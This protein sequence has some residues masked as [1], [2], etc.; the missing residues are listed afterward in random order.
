MASDRI[1]QEFIIFR[2]NNTAGKLCPQRQRELLTSVYAS[3][4]NF[5]QINVRYSC[6]VLR[7]EASCI[8]ASMRIVEVNNFY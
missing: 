8:F 3:K 2:S 5:H 6:L 4:R 7:L 1:L